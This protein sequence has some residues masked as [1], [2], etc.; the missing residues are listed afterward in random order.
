M[1]SLFCAGDF[2][3]FPCIVESD[4]GASIKMSLSAPEPEESWES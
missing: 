4:E 2:V 3:F 1:H